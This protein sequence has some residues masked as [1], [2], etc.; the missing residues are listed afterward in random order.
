MESSSLWQ[1]CLRLI[2]PFL[3]LRIFESSTPFPIESKSDCVFTEHSFDTVSAV[4]CIEEKFVVAGC[5]SGKLATATARPLPF[6]SALDASL[7]KGFCE[8]KSDS[9]DCGVGK[10]WASEVELPPFDLARSCPFSRKSHSI[11]ADGGVDIS[12]DGNTGKCSEDKF[13]AVECNVGKFADS[14]RIAAREKL[15]NKSVRFGATGNRLTIHERQP[16]QFCIER[17]SVSILCSWLL[18][19]QI[20]ICRR[21]LQWG[22]LSWRFNADRQPRQ[23]QPEKRF[24]VDCWVS[25]LIFVA[26]NCNKGGCLCG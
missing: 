24:A 18:S 16:I 5:W 17:D 21:Q 15:C 9:V 25:K 11:A 12:L 8:G 1:K 10:C 26:D 14:Q 20:D 7:E 6:E 4:N 22:G 19:L 23:L 2:S 13:V 3:N